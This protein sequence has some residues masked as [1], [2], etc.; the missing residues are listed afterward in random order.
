MRENSMVRSKFFFF[1]LV[2]IAFGTVQSLNSEQQLTPSHYYIQKEVEK[3]IHA[4]QEKKLN[5]EMLQ[6]LLHATENND[7]QKIH[8]LTDLS[9]TG[10]ISIIMGIVVGLGV[11]GCLCSYCCNPQHEHN[12][13]SINQSSQATREITTTITFDSWGNLTNIKNGEEGDESE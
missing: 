9:L 6:I 2:L 11:F 10:L 12:P 7:T 8:S 5:A 3:I 1:L 4:L 13:A